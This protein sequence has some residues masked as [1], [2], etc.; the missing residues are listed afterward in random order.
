MARRAR[1]GLV[2]LSMWRGS[3]PHRR[4]YHLGFRPGPAV[5]AGGRI[6]KADLG[7]RL[8]ATDDPEEA[9]AP[10]RAARPLNTER[11]EIEARV[12]D[13]AL[14]QAEERGLDAPLVWAA[15]R[16]LAS[17]RRGHRRLAPEGG[18][19]PPRRGD[20]VRRGEGKGSGRSVSGVD[21]GASIQRLA[22]EGC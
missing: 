14:A 3:T 19:Q 11:R 4:A 8:L 22:A 18:H 6:G 16:G 13:A 15:G 5:N 9:L 7:A 21:L 1:P 20:R 2:A 17:R 12:R 10:G